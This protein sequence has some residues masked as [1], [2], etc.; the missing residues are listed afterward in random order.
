MLLL[1]G[2]TVKTNGEIKSNVRLLI[3]HFDGMLP[4]LFITKNPT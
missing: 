2:L 3:V 4:E 1:V